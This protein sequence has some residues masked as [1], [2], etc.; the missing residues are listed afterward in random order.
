MKNGTCDL[1]MIGLGVMGLNLALNF[2]DH[3]FTI[4][5]F[6]KSQEKIREAFG[7][8]A[9]NVFVAGTL[10]D[11]IDLLKVPRAVMMLVPAGAPVDAVIEELIPYLQP[12]DLLIDGGNS[13]FKDTDLR[14]KRLSAVGIHFF[15]VGISGGEEGA[16]RG[17]SIMPGG[18]QMAYSRISQLLEA[19]AA[20]ADS[21]VCVRYLGPR[22]AGHFVKMVH[23]GI[24]YGIMQLISE[25]YDLLKRGLNCDNET[26]SKI[27]TSWNQTE[28]ESYLLEITGQIF[29]QNDPNTGEKL[30][31]QILDVSKQKGTGMWT[32]QVAMELQIPTPT[33]DL[34]VGMRHLSMQKELRQEGSKILSRKSHLLQVDL[35]VFVAKLRKAFYLASMITY[36][37]GMSLM[38]AASEKLK[39]E[40]DLQEIASIWK[41][42]CI[43]R[44]AFLEEIE[45][46]YQKNRQ[47]AHL[48]FDPAIAKKVLGLEEQLREVL[49]LSLECAIPVPGL[50]STLNY[51][52]G[53][54]SEWLPA[55][56]IQAQ[57]D[58]FGSHTYERIDQKGTFHT[59]WNL[60]NIK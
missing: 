31:D 11:F 59:K 51:L 7:L 18:S 14:V 9:H 6:D 45:H 16:R 25:T 40:L 23:N 13:Y 26:L 53:I 10:K 37:Q 39:Y 55:S 29:L 1:G 44:A 30:I 34:A 2:A 50:M 8:Q 20:K 36:A 4:A 58:F 28:L 5:C 17:P 42:G 27:F 47:L 35:E 46:A 48:L 57:R 24:E 52:D 32:T 41:G 49:K 60:E 56:L 3:G 43:I 21:T 22:S 12:D 33:I 54:R 38:Q 15:G 19:A